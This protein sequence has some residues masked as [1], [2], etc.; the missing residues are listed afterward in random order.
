MTTSA[1]TKTIWTQSSC[2]MLIQDTLNVFKPNYWYSF[3]EL[4]VLFESTIKKSQHISPFDPHHRRNI[5]T[6]NVTLSFSTMIYE[7]P[8]SLLMLPIISICSNQRIHIRHTTLQ[9]SK[10]CISIILCAKSALYL[11]SWQI[12][13]G[14]RLILKP[15]KE[16]TSM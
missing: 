3:R 9:A 11:V 2:W 8:Y 7:M 10:V 6:E 13:A 12:L 16:T 14:L 4:N 5:R 15:E 1:A